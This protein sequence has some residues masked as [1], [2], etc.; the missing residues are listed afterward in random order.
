M[1]VGKEEA[2]LGCSRPPTSTPALHLLSDLYIGLP[3]KKVL[4]V[5]VFE[6]Y[7]ASTSPRLVAVGL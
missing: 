6:N 3:Y 7:W 1:E 4:L 2:E 5:T